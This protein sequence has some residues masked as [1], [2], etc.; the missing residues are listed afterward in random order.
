MMKL[1][2]CVFA[3]LLLPGCIAANNG[4]GSGN[5]ELSDR[6]AALEEANLDSRVDVLESSDLAARVDSLEQEDLAERLFALEEAGLEGRLELLEGADLD[7][8]LSVQEADLADLNAAV[9]ALDV[10]GTDNA[11]ALSSNTTALSNNAA[12]ITT[13]ESDLDALETQTWVIDA[14]LTNLES[15]VASNVPVRT[16]LGYSDSLSVASGWSFSQMRSIGSFTKYG[17]ATH[18]RLVWLSHAGGNA[19]QG[20]CH[21]QLRI[22][23]SA[24]S[25][26]EGAIVEGTGSAVPVTVVQEYSGLSMGSHLVSLWVRRSGFGGTCFDNIG[27]YSRMVYVEEGPAN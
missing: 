23:G 21:F 7:E 11:T 22:D 17:T 25:N 27:D 8:R 6:L 9:A 14:D 24:G 19:T 26:G 2:P 3:L 4:S 10:Q 15:E 12:N 20:S 18:V 16:S 13:L 1:T 5:Q